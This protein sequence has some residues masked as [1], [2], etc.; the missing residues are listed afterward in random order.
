ML[1]KKLLDA[2][3]KK[4]NK[5]FLVSAHINLEGDA[6]GSELALASLLKR[7]GKKVIVLN[8][9]EPPVEYGFLPG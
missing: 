9:D 7:L 5:V 4:Q 1:P 3:R 2:L 6:L 8:Q